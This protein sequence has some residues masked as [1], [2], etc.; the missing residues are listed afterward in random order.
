MDTKC[1]PK[2]WLNGLE[3]CYGELFPNFASWWIGKS[4]QISLE[5]AKICFLL[6]SWCL[7]AVFWH[8]GQSGQHC[9]M[10]LSHLFAPHIQFIIKLTR[11][12]LYRFL[13]AKALKWSCRFMILVEETARRERWT[14]AMTLQRCLEGHLL[15]PR[16]S[17]GS[18][19]GCFTEA[20]SYLWCI[21]MMGFVILEQW[22]MKGKAHFAHCHATVFSI[23]SFLAVWWRSRT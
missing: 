22:I 16:L 3:I 19:T 9:K 8:D 14:L 13:L 17:Y 15:A 1:T 23:V 11:I 2:R 18:V 21:S 6:S 10:I 5:V 7:E 20:K 4:A 12:L